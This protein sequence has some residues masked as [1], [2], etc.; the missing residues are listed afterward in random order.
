MLPHRRHHD[1]QEVAVSW[2]TLANAFRLGWL[3]LLFWGERR[4]FFTA[5]EACDWDHWEI[6][7]AHAKP[8]RVAL[9]ADPQLIDPHTY[10][11]RGP[12]LAATMF[13]TDLYMSRSYSTLQEHLLP[14]TTIFLGDLFDGGREWATAKGNPL[15]ERQKKPE[16]EIEPDPHGSKDWKKYTHTYWMKEYV[17]FDTIFPALPGRRTV[18]SLPG[19]HDLGI[20]NGIKESV[21]DRWRAYFGLTS[22]VVEAGNHT[23]LLLDTVSLFNDDTPRIYE[24]PQTFLDSLPPTPV[25]EGSQPLEH[26]VYSISSPP[27]EALQRQEP[28]IK[29]TILLTH[30]PLWRDPD[31]PCGPDREKGNAIPIF[32][33]YQYQNVLTAQLSTEILHKTAA[34]WVFSGDDHDACSVEHHYGS[35]GVV[36]ETTVKSFSWAMGVRHPGFHMLSLWTGEGEAESVQAK[37]CLLPD[38]LGVFIVY[39]KAGVIT[40]VVLFLE[41]AVKALRKKTEELVLP[42]YKASGDQESMSTRASAVGGEISG[43]I[44]NGGG[45]RVSRMPSPLRTN[46][47]DSDEKNDDG[48]G[49]YWKSRVADIRA[50]RARWGWLYQGWKEV[51]GVV[52]FVLAAYFW[53]IWRW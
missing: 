53:L 44:G 21:L 34:R 14:H 7:P 19:N 5:I 25:E 8:H 49:K 18:K 43:L 22:S 46:I 29:P 32:Y 16:K 45:S 37:M 48:E 10:P 38:Q 11:R 35:R 12:A 47:P 15:S 52:F 13:Y 26:V 39:T 24:P 40:I 4:V 30:V 33:G 3:L 17:R 36:Q 1:W 2:V 50:I 9:I 31:T 23:V 27:P 20:A 51:R 42:T 6:W 41:A 28:Q